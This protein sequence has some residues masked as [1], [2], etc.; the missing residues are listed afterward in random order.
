MVGTKIWR[1][2]C[3]ELNRIFDERQSARRSVGSCRGDRRWR[4]AVAGSPLIA[5]A[6]A[7]K[8]TPQSSL[9]AALLPWTWASYEPGCACTQCI[10]SWPTGSSVASSGL[11]PVPKLPRLVP[12]GHVVPPDRDQTRTGPPGS[13]GCDLNGPGERSNTRSARQS[14]ATLPVPA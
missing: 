7:S 3:S 8:N 6:R 9:A 5:L 10:T 13:L 4:R 12:S 1:I 11:G 2:A 14:R